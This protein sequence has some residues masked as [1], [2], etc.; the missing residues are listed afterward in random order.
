MPPGKWG[1]LMRILGTKDAECFS[2]ARLPRVGRSGWVVYFSWKY[3][4]VNIRRA[5]SRRSRGCSPSSSGTWTWCRATSWRG[6]SCSGRGSRP[7]GSSSYHRWHRSK[8][9]LAGRLSHK[10]TYK[11]LNLLKP[12]LDGE[13]VKLSLLLTFKLFLM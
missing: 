7:P 1:G 4:E 6:S 10:R 12:S 3:I 13:I 8:I 5:H 2:A 11:N 9:I